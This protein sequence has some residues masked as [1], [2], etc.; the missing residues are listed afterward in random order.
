MPSNVLLP[1]PEPANSP[2]RWPLPIVVNA[3]IAR[4]PTS[5]GSVIASRLR[6][7][8]ASPRSAVRLSGSTSP[9]PSIY[10]PAPSSTRPI[11]SSPTATAFS[12]SSGITSAPIANPSTLDSGMSTSRPSEKPTISAT[13]F[14]VGATRTR[15]RLPTA[16]VQPAASILRPI[17]RTTRPATL[18]VSD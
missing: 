13:M 2:K 10:W 14:R 8:S 12:S 16:P 18:G 7:L 15:H 1:T 9:P 3:L 11:I 5:S 17:M 6:G 4:T